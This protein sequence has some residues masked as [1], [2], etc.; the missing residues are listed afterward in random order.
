MTDTTQNTNK[1]GVK[2]VDATTANATVTDTNTTPEVATAMPTD[3]VKKPVVND[4]KNE[5]KE[6]KKSE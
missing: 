5:K 3:A 2:K 4:V 1:D 6:E